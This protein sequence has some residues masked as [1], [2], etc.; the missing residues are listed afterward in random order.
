METELKL[1]N[2]LINDTDIIIKES[3]LLYEYYVCKLNTCQNENSKWLS[4]LKKN[5]DNI[6]KMSDYND[7]LNY[8]ANELDN[9]KNLKKKVFLKSLLNYRDEYNKFKL[10]KDKLDNLNSN[11]DKNIKYLKK[12]LLK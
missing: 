2:M 11:F 4:S 6:Y 9:F 10:D 3:K 7:C 12:E 5:K 1:R 8:C